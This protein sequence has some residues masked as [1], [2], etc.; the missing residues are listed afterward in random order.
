MYGIERHDLEEL[1]Q[2]SKQE[3]PTAAQDQKKKHWKEFL[4]NTDNVWAAAKYMSGN[5]GRTPITALKNDGEV[6]EDG[7]DEAR[8]F[9]TTFYPPHPIRR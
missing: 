9:L 5:C 2:K 1:A 6:I 7:A 3:F 8:E 4:Q